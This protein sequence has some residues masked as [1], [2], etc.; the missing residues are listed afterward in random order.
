MGG[1]RFRYEPRPLAQRRRTGP[2]KV[3]RWS[4]TVRACSTFRFAISW[5]FSPDM[6]NACTL[7]EK[8]AAART[9]VSVST[10]LDGA[11]RSRDRHL[12]PEAAGEEDQR[13]NSAGFLERSRSGSRFPDAA[14]RALLHFIVNQGRGPRARNE[15]ENAGIWESSGGRPPSGRNRCCTLRCI[16]ASSTRLHGVDPARF[17]EG[18]DHAKQRGLASYHPRG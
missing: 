14:L 17:E 18:P 15:S 8:P 6:G 13:G 11:D 4:S 2:E 10:V 12:W 1:G 9:S 3:L 5:T 7:P 16:F